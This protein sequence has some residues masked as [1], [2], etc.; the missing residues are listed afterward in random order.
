MN[1][2]F[3]LSN[4]YKIQCYVNF[5]TE[6]HGKNNVD[7]HFGILSRWFSEGESVQNI[8]TINNLINLFQNKAS[9]VSIQVD[10][11]FTYILNQEIK[12]N[13]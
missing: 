9:K 5:F 7:E 6:Y 11:L 3:E 13:N 4:F 12:F 2:I 10:L 1:Y 8:F